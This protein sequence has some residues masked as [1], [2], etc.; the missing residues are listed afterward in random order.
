MDADDDDEDSSSNCSQPSMTSQQ[1]QPQVVQRLTMVSTPSTTPTPTTLMLVTSN[2]TAIAGA[3]AVRPAN[4]PGVTLGQTAGT[5]TAITVRP[6]ANGMGAAQGGLVV[7]SGTTVAGTVAASPNVITQGGMPATLAVRAAGNVAGI[8]PGSSKTHTILVMPVSSTASSTGVT[9][10]AVTTEV[11]PA[12][13]R[14][15][16]E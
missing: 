13:K 8:N 11:P 12:A 2:A 6:T 5:P 10:T 9:G 15:K 7:L 1:Q 16:T 14:V 4:P 3:G